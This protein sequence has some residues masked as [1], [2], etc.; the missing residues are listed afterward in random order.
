MKR[1]VGF[2]QSS[3]QCFVELRLHGNSSTCLSLPSI[4]TQVQLEFNDFVD[5][6]PTEFALLVV[7]SSGLQVRKLLLRHKEVNNITTAGRNMMRG[8]FGPGKMDHRLDHN[9]LAIF[10]DG[11]IK[12]G[13][14]SQ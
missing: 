11:S 2:S 13:Y 1:I 8:T 3:T 5:T 10:E 12:H 4:T 9:L 7:T 14:K 6:Q